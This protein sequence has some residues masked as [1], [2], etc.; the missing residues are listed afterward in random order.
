MLSRRFILILVFSLAATAA[1]FGQVPPPS[2]NTVGAPLD[3]MTTLL[4]VLGSTL[5]AKRLRDKRS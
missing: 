2:N 3:G 5:G 4:I 1:V